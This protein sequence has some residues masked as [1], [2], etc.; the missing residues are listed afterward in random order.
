LRAQQGAFTNISGRGAAQVEM[1]NGLQSLLS[2]KLNMH[3]DMAKEARTSDAS[4]RILSGGAG[5]STPRHYGLSETNVM[6]LQRQLRKPNLGFAVLHDGYALM[7]RPQF[8]MANIRAN[9]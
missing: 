8:D 6:T 3:Q 7:I 5:G 2:L 1:L 4:Q 9:Q